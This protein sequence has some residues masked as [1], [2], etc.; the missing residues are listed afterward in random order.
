M[1]SSVV[2]SR[3]EIEQF[4]RRRIFGP[5]KPYRKQTNHDAVTRKRFFA[6][7]GFVSEQGDR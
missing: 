3:E 5:G 4:Q 7:T 6:W 1:V 2:R